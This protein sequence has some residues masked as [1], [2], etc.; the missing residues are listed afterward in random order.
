MYELGDLEKWKSERGAVSLLFA[1]LFSSG[2]IIGLFVIVADVSSIYVERRVVQNAADASAI[3]L[4]QECAL[5]GYG[6]IVGLNPSSASRV[7]NDESSYRTFVSK[8]ANINSPDSLTNITSVC[9]NS[10]TAACP[11]HTPEGTFDCNAVPSQYRNFVRVKT[12]TQSPNSSSLPPIF[13]SALSGS[14]TSVDIKGCTNAAWGKAGSA[15]V[16]LPFALPICKWRDSFRDYIKEF[17]SNSTTTSCSFTDLEGVTRSINGVTPGFALLANFG[18]PTF[19][20]N[21]NPLQVGAIL[22]IERALSR[23]EACANNIPANYFYNQLSLLVNKTLFLPIVTQILCETSSGTYRPITEVNCG[24][25]QY[26][27]QVAGFFGFKYLGSKLQNNFTGIGPLSGGAWPSDCDSNTNCLYGEFSRA[28]VP[29]A[30]ISTDT[31]IPSVG[32]LAVQLLT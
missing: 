14:T 8:Y 17:S 20:V 5:G 2:L 27:F 3:A 30:D 23:V 16:F 31:T 7:C 6:E 18:C 32:A 9:V 4:A 1:I 19:D 29:G 25:G 13:A 21:R 11:T 22:P 12:D 15:P 26:R 10:L 24:Q 28:I